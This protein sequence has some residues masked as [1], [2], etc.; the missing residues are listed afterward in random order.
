MISLE[1]GISQ[2]G[3]ER[4]GPDFPMGTD[5]KRSRVW[6]RGQEA[7]ELLILLWSSQSWL[8]L[9]PLPE[10][11]II[12]AVAMDI[13]RREHIKEGILTFFDLQPQTNP[14]GCHT[15]G[16][17]WSRTADHLTA[18][19]LQCAGQAV[20]EGGQIKVQTP[21]RVATSFENVNVYYCPACNYQYFQGI[22]PFC[23]HSMGEAHKK[24]VQ[25]VLNDTRHKSEGA[26]LCRA[27]T[28]SAQQPLPGV[29]LPQVC[30]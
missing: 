22:T 2:R 28:A 11:V 24:K 4:R 9:R 16:P 14:V 26:A 19:R 10:L 13:R 5:L 30:I 8:S 6:F 17:D 20:G 21:T 7:S 23:Q 12:Q 15:A 3:K 18:R 29:H 1:E 25:R 27:T